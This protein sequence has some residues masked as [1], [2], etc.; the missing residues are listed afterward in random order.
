MHGIE[1]RYWINGLSRREAFDAA[2]AEAMDAYKPDLI[3]LAGFMRT[4]EMVS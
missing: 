2:L 1:T 4:W 3:A